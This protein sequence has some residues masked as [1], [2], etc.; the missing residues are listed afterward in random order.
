MRLWNLTLIFPLFGALCACDSANRDENVETRVLADD[1]REAPA[2]QSDAVRLPVVTNNDGDS[3]IKIAGEE[4]EVD[5][6]IPVG[7]NNLP[8]AR[9]LQI[10]QSLVPGEVLKVELDDDDGIPE[11]EIEM[12]NARGRKIKIAIDARDGSIRELERD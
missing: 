12:L 9:I 10:A 1:L 5:E 11:Y 2:D 4:D 6:P 8:L 3:P 7:E